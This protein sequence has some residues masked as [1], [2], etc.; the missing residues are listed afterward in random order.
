MGAYLQRSRHGTIFYFR[1]KLPTD[2][3]PRLNVPQLFVSL[4]TAD[5]SVAM[6][7]ARRAATRCDELF[8][9]LRAMATKTEHDALMQIIREWQRTF[10]LREEIWRLRD[11][12]QE[13]EYQ[14]RRAVRDI[15]RLKDEH[16]EQM[17]RVARAAGPAAA[18]ALPANT[19]K[20]SEAIRQFMARKDMKAKS[21]M[22]FRSTLPHFEK[23]V[24]GETWIHEVT[25]ARV[26]DYAEAV[27]AVTKSADMTKKIYI[28]TAVTMLQWHKNSKGRPVDPAITA[29]SLIPKRTAPAAMDRDA[30]TVEQLGVLFQ[31]A[32]AFYK[33]EPHWFWAVVVPAFLGCRIQELAQADLRGDFKTDKDT[34]RLYLEV[35]ETVGPGGHRKSVK[36][37]SSWRAVPV[38]HELVRLGFA[39]YIE[40]EKKAKA[41]TLFERYWAPLKLDDGTHDFAHSITKRGSRVIAR[42]KA[43]G[44]LPHGKT[45]AFHSLRHTLV[46]HLAAK[47]VP[48]DMRSAIVGHAEG[49]MG[50]VY[51]KLRYQIAPKVP[52][53]EDNLSEYVEQLRAALN[54]AGHVV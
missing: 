4:G 23:F 33:T 47:G 38:H 13:A 42:L 37:A 16:A 14:R 25:Q 29:R 27:K 21:R 34:G 12:A 41:R 40:R 9:H 30:F 53:I 49:G 15:D 8:Q 26:A 5:R 32:A 36:K 44:E 22:R 46:S 35:N 48:S 52:V 17:V 3:R 2:L 11:E 54:A 20:I 39:D 6:V 7:L 1:R 50:A 10:P 19:I 31:H 43:S 28:T 24:G 45:T 18:T 51:S